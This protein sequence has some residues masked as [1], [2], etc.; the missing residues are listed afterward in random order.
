MLKLKEYDNQKRESEAGTEPDH[1]PQYEMTCED[2]PLA[3]HLLTFPRLS[4][5]DK[6]VD[7][8][9]LKNRLSNF[10]FIHPESGQPGAIAM[11]ETELPILPIVI[12]LSLA[13]ITAN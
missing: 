9:K 10:D 7:T 11:V 12:L 13:L 8:N 1:R 3:S 5:N 2:T 4:V 6:K